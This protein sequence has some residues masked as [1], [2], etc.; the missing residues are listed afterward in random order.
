M[1]KAGMTITVVVIAMLFAVPMAF[2]QDDVCTSIQ[3]LIKSGHDAA[4]VVRTSIDLG[5]SPCE[6]VKCAYH[7]GGDLE[8]IIHGA[9]QA[10]TSPDVVSSCLIEAGATSNAI[11]AV[12]A[13]RNAMGAN[14]KPGGVAPPPSVASGLPGDSGSG[15]GIIISPSQF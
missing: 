5:S 7:G 12:Y 6:V 8:F 3:E 14:Y 1:K 2:A 9:F 11:E 4:V 10:N 13:K 15:D